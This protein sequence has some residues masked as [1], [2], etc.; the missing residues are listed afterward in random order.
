MKR[1]I[2]LFVFCLFFKRPP[3]LADARLLLGKG[4]YGCGPF[5]S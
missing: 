3:F 1:F 5:C 4:K 2:Y